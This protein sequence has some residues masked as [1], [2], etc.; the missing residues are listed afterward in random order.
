MSLEEVTEVVESTPAPEAVVQDAAPQVE[1]APEQVEAAPEVPAFTPEFK[2]LHKGKPQ[3]VDEFF[4]PLVKD[5]ESQSRVIESL[6]KLNAIEDYRAKIQEYEPTVQMVSKVQSLYDKGDHEAVLEQIGYT[7]E[8][9]LNIA[10]AKL[11]RMRMP[12]EQRAAMEKER[13]IALEKEQ[14]MS[15]NEEY[16]RMVASERATTLNYQIKEALA[17]PEF[18]DLISTYESRSGKGSFENVLIQRG[19]V[20]SHM[21][22][23]TVAPAEV[24]ASLAQEYAAFIQPMAAS[25]QATTIVPKQKP[26]VIPN[27][28]GNNASAERGQVRSIEDI[29]KLAQAMAAQE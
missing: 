8:D 19:N 21:A 1:A 23:K 14:L 12:A 13:S 6:Q 17:K 4:R 25:P 22:G 18:Q 11:E 27:V 15:Q 20:M 26:K 9:I 28:N 5:P 2:Y 16:Q 7:D 3:E 24:L 29:K 10:R